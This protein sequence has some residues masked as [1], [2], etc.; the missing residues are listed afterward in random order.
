LFGWKIKKI[1]VKKDGDIMHYWM[2]S[3][4][5]KEHSNEKS[6]LDGGL[7]KRQHPQQ[8]NL[9]YLSVSSIDEYSNKVNELG[10]KVVLPKT[11][12]TGYGFFAVCIDRAWLSLLL[13][14]I[15]SSVIILKA[16]AK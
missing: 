10:D 1:E 5:S 12:I 3:T 11:E 7:I 6:S 15:C 9:N 2:I 14:I 16:I 4:S 8:P 13:I